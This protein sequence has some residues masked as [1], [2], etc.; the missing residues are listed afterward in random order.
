M[1]LG[2]LR[3]D[4]LELKVQAS[5]PSVLHGCHRTKGLS[6]HWSQINPL[7]SSIGVPV[8]SPMVGCEHLHLYWSGCGR[9]SQDTVVSG[10]C[11]QVL[12]DSSNSVWVWCLHLGWIPRSSNLWMAFPSV[13]APLFVPVFPLKRNISGLKLWT[14]V[15]G[16]IHQPGALPNLWIWS[17]Q[18]LPPLCGVFQLMS[19]LRGPGRLLLSWHL[20]LSGCYPQLPLPHC[21]TALF[22]IMTLWFLALKL[23]CVPATAR[24][25]GVLRNTGS[26][27]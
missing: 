2:R 1:T 16:P 13:S 24:S 26:A 12:L 25:T 20:E 5:T 9:A 22:N 6:C 7:S 23:K 11:L 21:Y 8:L 4:A 17:Q 10:S 27:I 14:W 18:V 3:T 19:S 15:G